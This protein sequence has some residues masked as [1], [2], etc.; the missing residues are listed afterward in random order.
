MK[1]NFLI[2]ILDLFLTGQDELSKKME[3]TWS[4]SAVTEKCESAGFISIRLKANRLEKA[5]VFQKNIK[6][7]KTCQDL[8]FFFTVWKVFTAI[9]N[10]FFSVKPLHSFVKFVSFSKLIQGIH[11]TVFWIQIIIIRKEQNVLIFSKEKE[12]VQ[13]LCQ[14]SAHIFQWRENLQHQYLR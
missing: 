11:Q 13:V 2:F 5:H 7:M 4:D 10:I 8:C 3:N 1:F 12:G 14:I 9:T 6:I